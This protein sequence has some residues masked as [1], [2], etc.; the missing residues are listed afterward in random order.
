M[1]SDSQFAVAMK[2]Q[3]EAER[4]EQ[5]RIKNLVLNYDLQDS[6]ADSGTGSTDLLSDPFSHPN[7]NFRAPNPLWIPLH[8]S[9]RVLTRSNML[10]LLYLKVP[11]QASSTNTM[12]L[13][14]KTPPTMRQILDPWTSLA[15]TEADTEPGNCS[16]VMLIGMTA[17]RIFLQTPWRRA[18]PAAVILDAG[19]I[20][21]PHTVAFAIVE[22]R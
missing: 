16:S 22:N 10:T 2:N 6:S 19:L 15:R 8:W 5:Q 13:C 7:P 21:A 12:L 17:A 20:V 9:L 4:A 1:P 14:T 18:F 11:V 3:Q